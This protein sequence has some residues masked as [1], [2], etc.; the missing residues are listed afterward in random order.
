M[1]LM[2]GFEPATYRLQICY[3]TSC[4]TP[5]YQLA[6]YLNVPLAVGL[7]TTYT[8]ICVLASLKGLEPS[9]NR[10]EIYGSFQLSYSDIFGA[11]KG[12]QSTLPYEMRLIMMIAFDTG[13]NFNPH[14]RMRCDTSHISSSNSMVI[15][16]HA[17]M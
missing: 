7:S 17:P 2:A 15:S 9:T 8:R 5:A 3:A 6:R 14:T 1:E 10:V 16:I 11:T 4:V 12:F 13:A